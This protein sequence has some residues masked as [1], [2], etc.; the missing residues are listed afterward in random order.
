MCCNCLSRCFHGSTKLQKSAA[1]MLP[2]FTV[3]ETFGVNSAERREITRMRAARAGFPHHPRCFDRGG[4]GW[5]GS[6][7]GF[8]AADLQHL[9]S[10]DMFVSLLNLLTTPR[11]VCQTSGL[12][13]WSVS[14]N[15]S[16]AAW[17]RGPA[18]LCGSLNMQRRSCQLAA[19]CRRLAR[20]TALV[21]ADIFNRIVTPHMPPFLHPHS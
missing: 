20:L 4:G 17:L 14:I 3:M 21:G 13:G 5:A 6:W 2:A 16:P 9:R 18:V 15:D 19:G 7:M 10:A 12:A 1:A 8:T 11:K